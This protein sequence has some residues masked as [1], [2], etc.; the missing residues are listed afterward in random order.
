MAVKRMRKL[1]IPPSIP[2]RLLGPFAC[3][4][5]HGAH[6][7]GK[8]F[9]HYVNLVNV[10]WT[11]ITENAKPKPELRPW[12]TTTETRQYIAK[13]SGYINKCDHECIIKLIKFYSFVHFSKEQNY[14]M[15]LPCVFLGNKWILCCKRHPHNKF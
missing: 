9:G 13:C 8:L 6:R 7:T 4:F 14:T 3:H 15:L 1:K 2:G 5:G 11:D 10:M 12:K